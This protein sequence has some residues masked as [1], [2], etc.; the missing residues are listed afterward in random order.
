MSQSDPL[1][2]H[3]RFWGVR[4]GTAV[5]G[6]GTV[7]YG[8]NTSCVAVRCGPHLVVLDAGSGIRGLGEAL[9]AGGGAV[10]ADILCS[11]THLDH[12]C[13]IPWFA[14]LYHPETSA[15]FWAANLTPP[16]GLQSVVRTV[17][18]H[19]LNP[20][21]MDKMR[22]RLRFT[23]FTAGDT[24]ELRPGLVALTAPLRH[25][26]GSTGYRIEWSGRA[27]AYIT[28]T[29]HTPGQPDAN[30]LRLAA[31][32]DV[33]IF[34]ASYSDA[35]YPLH[36]GWGHATWQEG[37]RIARA[38]GAR[39]LV[40]YHHDSKRDDA[41]LDAVAAEA[42]AALPGVIMAREGLEIAL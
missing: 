38:A 12:I 35:E 16:H 7:R 40:L 1:D 41:C 32:A 37:I 21:L 9:Q 22:A 26:G 23:D 28:D 30:V 39:R 29:E 11:H 33:L 8:G 15:R 3:L 24:L 31:G 4:G 18:S 36:V 5:P 19:P 27:V 42:E 13:G 34:D 10:D 2:F 25:P 20:D 14:P 17:L 6:M